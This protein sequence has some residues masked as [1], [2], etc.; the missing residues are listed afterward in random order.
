MHDRYGW[1]GRWWDG[2][3]YKLQYVGR[4]SV[5]FRSELASESS[6]EVC[7]VGHLDGLEDRIFPKADGEKVI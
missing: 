3:V 2:Q 6:G 5:C 7:R 4:F 1:L